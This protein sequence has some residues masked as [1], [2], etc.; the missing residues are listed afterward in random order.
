MVLTWETS[1]R[2]SRRSSAQTKWPSCRFLPPRAE[3]GSSRKESARPAPL[4]PE[5]DHPRSA[6]GVQ[7]TTVKQTSGGTAFQTPKGPTFCPKNV[8]GKLVPGKRLRRSTRTE[9][10][11][12]ER[13]CT[14]RICNAYDLP[15]LDD[16][17][18]CSSCQTRWERTAGHSEEMML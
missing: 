8:F 15:A 17:R 18:G 10:K 6:T 9:P 2:G 4:G 13:P 14:R 12:T 1:R 11:R 16:Q 7:K 3:P 5:F